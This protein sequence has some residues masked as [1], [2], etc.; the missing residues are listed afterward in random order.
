M[1]VWIARR[2]GETLIPGECHCCMHQRADISMAR[3][4]RTMNRFVDQTLDLLVLLA[5]HCWLTRTPIPLCHG[6]HGLLSEGA[7]LWASIVSQL[8]AAFGRSL[9]LL[10]PCAGLFGVV[11]KMPPAMRS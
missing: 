11:K 9:S 4:P 7:A 5:C 8:K 10:S 6:D 3:R 1:C 2:L